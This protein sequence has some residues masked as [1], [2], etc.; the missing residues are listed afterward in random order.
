MIMFFNI[1]KSIFLGIIQGITEWLPISST[2]HMLLFDMIIKLDVTEGFKN[3]FF[4]VIQLG[5]ILA[6]VLIYFKRLNPLSKKLNQ[7]KRN[8]IIRLWIKIIVASVPAGIAGLLFDETIEK[9]FHGPT[10]IAIALIGYGILFIWMEN[11]DRAHNPMYE[12]TTDIT[13]KA[14]LL[15]G[16]FQMLALIPGTS[17]SG[18]T[19]LGA[20]LLGCSR[21][22]AAEFSFFMAIPIMFG[23]SFYKIVKYIF[24][25]L[26]LD[27]SSGAVWA[28]I[29]Q[30]FVILLIGFIV[31]F[32]VSLFVIRFLLDYIRKHDFKVFGYYRIGLGSLIAIIFFIK[33]MISLIAG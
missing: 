9:V 7:P 26:D 4:V 22:A 19:I 29:G 3:L 33:W 2:G 11:T 14:A 8:S 31:A 24:S 10:T 12:K 15:I 23:A 18:A 13:Y 27:F 6:V 17:R 30:E 5:S 25:H 32:I 16:A 1:L 21:L 28:V 20:V